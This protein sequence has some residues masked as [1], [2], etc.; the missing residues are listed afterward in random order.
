MVL[1]SL[2]GDPTASLALG[3]V[4]ILCWLGAQAPQ[5][6]ENYR[7]KSC[8]GLALPFLINWMCGDATNFLGCILTDRESAGCV[9]PLSPLLPDVRT[10]PMT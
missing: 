9:L 10:D 7:L 8:D 6:I 3:Y 2:H 4:S 1:A 5:V